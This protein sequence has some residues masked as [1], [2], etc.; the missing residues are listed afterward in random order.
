MKKNTVSGI[1]LGVSI[2]FTL[3][4]LIYSILLINWKSEALQNR[5]DALEERME[6]DRLS[7]E[8]YRESL[9]AD[10]DDIRTVSGEMAELIDSESRLIQDEHRRSGNRLA[11]QIRT[12]FANVDERFNGL[13]QIVV[14]GEAQPVR[15][16]GG[17][18]ETIDLQIIRAMREGIA[19]FEIRRFPDAVQSFKSV[20]DLDPDHREAQLYTSI[21]LYYQNKNNLRQRRDTKNLL[22][23]VLDREPGNTIVLETLADIAAEEGSWNEAILFYRRR[24]ELSAAGAEVYGQAG[25]AC[26]Y[27]GKIQDSIDYFA[28]AIGRD[29]AESHYYYGA[30]RAYEI[31]GNTSRAAELYRQCL[32]RNPEHSEARKGYEALKTQ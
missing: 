3:V 8:Q 17:R 6:N 30:G 9:A 14:P 24:V 31:S 18:I 29:P 7:M 23:A 1:L 28:Q 16:P 21:S 4:L 15:V 20:L 25:F 27:A 13:E 26:L 32:A 22:T 2:F 10:L 5:L 11:G 12:G 19:A